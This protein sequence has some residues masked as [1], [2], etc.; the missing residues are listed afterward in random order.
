MIGIAGKRQPGNFRDPLFNALHARDVSRLVLR[1]GAAPAVDPGEDWPRFQ[2]Q[3]IPEFAVHRL[4]DL[5]IAETEYSFIARA[6]QEAAQDAFV[7]D[8]KS[9]RLNS[10]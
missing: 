5:V 6:P 1:H 8:R 7:L 4:Q 3:N 9:T 10:S 2:L